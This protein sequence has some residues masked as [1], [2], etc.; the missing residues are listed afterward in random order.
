[1]TTNRNERPTSV[2]P[3]P[4]EEAVQPV[5]GAT[6]TTAPCIDVIVPVYKGLA[7]TQRCIRSV[8]ASPC[9]VPFRLI[10][11]NDA[12]PEPE[13][14]AWLRSLAGS[15]PRYVLLE[16][17]INLGFVKTVNRG[18]ALNAA[19][20]VILLNSD[21]EV[22]NDWLDRLAH[23]AYSAP[24]V[25]SVT[26]FS[27]NATIFSYPRFCRD[28]ALPAGF[29][30]ARLDQ[31]FARTH[32]GRTLEVP[33]GVGFCMFIRRD[34]LREIGLFDE[35]HFGKGYGEENDFC[36]RATDAGWTH[37]HAL[38]TFVMH[39]G[40]VSFGASKSPREQAA[41]ETLRRL[42]P[43]Y[44]PAVHRFVMRD[45]A[46]AYRHAADLARVRESGLPVILAVLHDRGGGTLRHVHELAGYLK[47]EAVFFSL[48]P[49]PGKRVHV[50][51][52]GD[53]QSF[54]L[55]FDLVNGFDD[56]LAFLKTIGVSH[57]H[58]HHLLGHS[59][60][61]LG[62]PDAL[63]TRF[64][65]TAHDFFTICPQISL[66]DK[67]N[68]YCGEL[69][70]AQCAECLR[71]SPAPGNA[72]IGTWR[73]RH[74]RFLERA[75]YVLTPGSDAA[76]RLT[77]QL[78]GI[79]IQVVP[80]LDLVHALPRAAASRVLAPGAALKVAVIGA[81]SP[82]KGA[83]ILEETAVKAGHMKACI[84]FH[85]IGF[86]YRHL[87]TGKR[88]PLTVHGRYDESQLHQMLTTIQPDLV[89]FPAQ[90]PETYSYTLS[91]CLKMG[92]PVVASNFGAFA[93][94]LS[95]RE[96]SWLKPW[97][98]SA[99]EWLA[100]FETIRSANF[101]TGEGPELVPKSKLVV[102][103]LRPE[104]A[105]QYKRDYLEGLQVQTTPP[106]TLTPEFLSLHRPAPRGA[107]GGLKARL[108]YHTLT[109]LVNL[110]AAPG[111]R[112]LAR[113]IPLRLQTRLKSWLRS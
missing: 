78:P 27:N 103:P 22:A 111:L 32:A 99:S 71:V 70:P 94:R 82:I 40:G 5:P 91:A 63:G 52:L 8:L 37:L 102:F 20:D 49:A 59:E 11:I 54:G 81:L 12:S 110:R 113:A 35:N 17:E 108:R 68:G 109:A 14:T 50:G 90:W 38:D 62:L 7:D 106:A 77:R 97:N 31:L 2:R 47:I 36:C 69:G 9:R 10:A 79:G 51:L 48:T 19:N 18:M 53:G 107:H 29:D 25:A 58:Y 21:T 44:E 23:A 100:F 95:G 16:N 93:E 3:R 4:H 98:T 74:A 66:T 46:Q 24:R 56:L 64:D 43:T 84:E 45:P 33:T 39:A 61:I 88:V 13:V 76:Q 60:K 89:W 87:R 85:L 72:D 26:P 6:A 96:W 112:I 73:E 57:V 55:E 30:T 28:N 67:T 34:S 1:M 104:G 92:L 83:D 86:G 75:R 42:H 80:H 65:F 41:M 101:A 15:D 105:W